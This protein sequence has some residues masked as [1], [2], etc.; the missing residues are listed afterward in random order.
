MS[1]NFENKKL[2]VEEI[3]QKMSTAKVLVF[4]DY[5]GVN[6]AE[7]TNLRKT[8]RD[9]S[10]DYKVYKNRLMLR[11]ANELGITGLEETLNGTTAV[12]FGYEDEVGAPKL[13]EEFIKSTKKLVIKAGVV[14]GKLV[15]VD[16][17]KKLATIPSK[18]ELIS[19][20]LRTLNGPV[21]GLARALDAIASKQ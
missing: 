7:D 14:D 9:S 15:S 12:A 1:A 8:M 19:M 5:S 11:A 4:V 20:L 6:V 16:E 17:V 13:I 18:S 21:S 10:A 2:I 3:K